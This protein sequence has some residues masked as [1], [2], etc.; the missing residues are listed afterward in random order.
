[1]ADRRAPGRRNERAGGR[2][3]SPGKS[4][5]HRC[6]PARRGAGVKNVGVRSY[7]VAN[8]SFPH[9]STGDQ[10][11][12]ESQFESYRALGFELMDDILR[13]GTALLAKSAEVTLEEILT[14]L[15]DQAV[16]ARMP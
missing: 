4:P 6:C 15:R 10:F 13:R 5:D 12:S 3:P 9:Q 8:P 7:A 16:E 2:R 11:F 1:M 14:A